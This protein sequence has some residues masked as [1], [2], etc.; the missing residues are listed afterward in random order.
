MFSLFKKIRFAERS[1]KWS[2]V[3]KDHLKQNPCCAAC[4]AKNKQEVHHIKP[5][6]L[7][8]D[9]ELDVS[10]LITLCAD[11]CH[12][13]FGHLMNFKSWNEDVSKDCSVYYNKIQNRP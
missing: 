10:N 1:P 8:P 6:H 9:L 12:I 3:R 4:G 11:P 2:K 7:F 13:T 5:V